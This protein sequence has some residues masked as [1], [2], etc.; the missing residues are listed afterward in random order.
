MVS[1]D[2][3]PSDPQLPRRTAVAVIGGGIVGVSTALELAERGIDVT[4]I[5]K[6]IIAG[7]QSSRNW[8]WCRQMG[9]DAREAPLIIESL[10]AWRRMNARVGAETGFKQC[11]IIYLCETDEELAVRQKWQD[12]VAR[13]NG[14]AS[15][16]VGSEEAEK[17]QPGA[18]R[19]W[20]GALYTESD[21]RAEPIMAAPAIAK[22]ARQ[23]GA[24][25]LTH[26]AVRGL[27]TS[28]GRVS[29]IV[30]ERGTIACDSVVLAGGA[31]SRRFCHNIGVRFPQLSVVNSVMRTEPIDAGLERTC[32]AGLF[33][34][35][36][37]LDGGYTDRKSTRLNSS[38]QI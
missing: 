10:N 11:G 38:H 24:K 21:G 3:V 35:R 34:L 12:E 26:C 2:P 14:I 16:V 20:V 5:E 9:R 18:T 29:A 33:A 30:T 25:I 8:G 1:P 37:R 31:W 7:E 32:S 17:L 23:K 6:G 27:E 19:K 36:K 28:A 15:R 13:P 4:L 22:G